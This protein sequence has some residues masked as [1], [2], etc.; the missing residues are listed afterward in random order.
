[1]KTL[2]PV[3]HPS[4]GIYLQVASDVRN[5]LVLSE[6]GGGDSRLTCHASDRT[7]SWNVKT[8]DIELSYRT[9]YRRSRLHLQASS[10]SQ[11][12]DIEGTTRTSGR[13]FRVDIRVDSEGRRQL[14]GSRWRHESRSRSCVDHDESCASKRGQ[15]PPL[16]AR[17]CKVH[18]CLLRPS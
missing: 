5:H 8:F 17:A 7:S 6:A 12:N 9:R 4:T 11:Y 10:I 13:G 15:C 18:Q 1:M 14:E 2:I 3:Y 16:H